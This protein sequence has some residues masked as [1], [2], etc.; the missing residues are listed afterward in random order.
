[1]K[2][3]SGFTLLELM[4]GVAVAA[5]LL[6]IGIPS[7][8]SSVKQNQAMTDAN[9]L[10]R[11]LTLARSEALARGQT[12]TLCVSSDGS[13]CDTASGASWTEG[14]LLYYT[15]AGSTTAATLKTE[16]PFSKGST[17]SATS[18][19]AKALSFNGAGSAGT[20]DTSNHFAAATGTFTVLP[21]SQPKYTRCV[22]VYTSGRVS[23]KNPN[24][25]TFSCT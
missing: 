20:L 4:V 15:P 22:T 8:T 24:A 10:S 18:A 7:F 9:S 13:S 25:T 21:N 3:N 14:Y 12:V 17:I 11:L 5:I 2:G 23:I 16:V 1:M 19:F 6:T